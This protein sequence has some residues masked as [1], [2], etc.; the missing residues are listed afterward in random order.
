M[1]AF[2]MTTTQ[3]A[4]GIVVRLS[5]S[6]E[7]A[8]CGTLDRGLMG[9]SANKAKLVIF[10][11]SGVTFI[12]SLAMGSLVAFRGGVVRTGGRVFLAGMSPLVLDCFKRPRLTA[13]FEVRDSVDQCLSTA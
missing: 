10:E 3:I 6:L 9:L 12:A 13:L 1:S 8:A 7:L 2:T 11:M 4:G 5:G